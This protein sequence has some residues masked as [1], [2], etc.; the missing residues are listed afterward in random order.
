MF[1][2]L[3]I[4]RYHQV[5]R[6][7]QTAWVTF[8]DGTVVVCSRTSTTEPWQHKTEARFFPSRPTRPV[9]REL[10][11]RFKVKPKSRFRRF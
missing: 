5:I 10:T 6:F 9:G 7:F 3:S 4:I 2:S 1:S 8:E 11:C